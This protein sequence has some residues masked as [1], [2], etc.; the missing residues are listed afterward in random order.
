MDN[1]ELKKKI[2]DPESDVLNKK[3]NS[4]IKFRKTKKFVGNSTSKYYHKS[5]GKQSTAIKEDILTS[6]L[7]FSELKKRNLTFL[8]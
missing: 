5:T 4:G 8:S 6:T 7:L 2:N 1:E 3:Y